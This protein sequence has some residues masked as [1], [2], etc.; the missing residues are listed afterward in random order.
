MQ[1]FYCYQL[2]LIANDY[3]I[4]L[5]HYINMAFLETNKEYYCKT[6]QFKII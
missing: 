4:K 3:I 5:I 6:F 2:K 1:S